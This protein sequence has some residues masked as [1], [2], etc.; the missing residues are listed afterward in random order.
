[1]QSACNLI[2]AAAIFF[3]KLAPSMKIAEN[4]LNTRDAVFRVNPDRNTAPIIVDCNRVIW[5][6]DN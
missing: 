3:I 2:S 5:V 4:K 6:Y 1:M